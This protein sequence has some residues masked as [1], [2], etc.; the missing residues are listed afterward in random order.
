MNQIIF[1]VVIVLIEVTSIFTC[2]YDVYGRKARLHVS[3]GPVR[4]C[5]VATCRKGERPHICTEDYDDAF[6]TPCP[7]RKYNSLDTV[8]SLHILR[9]GDCRDMS[10]CNERQ[11]MVSPGN[12][13]SDTDCRCDIKRGYY[14]EIPDQRNADYCLV[15]EECDA[16]TQLNISGHCETC[17]N[18]TFKKFKGHN[19]C[20]PCTKC[21]T[22]GI[23]VIVNCT[24]KENTICGIIKETSHTASLLSSTNDDIVNN[25]IF[26]VITI[27][28][29]I[30]IVITIS[31]LVYRIKLF[32]KKIPPS[33]SSIP[34][35]SIET[36]RLN[37]DHPRTIIHVAPGANVF[38]QRGEKNIINKNGEDL[39]IKEEEENCNNDDDDIVIMVEG[40]PDP[41]PDPDP[42]PIMSAMMIVEEPSMSAMMIVEEPEPSMSAMM[43]VEEP[44]MSAMMIVEEPS[45]SAMT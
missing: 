3:E 14:S 6:C 27:S 40:E 22:I 34:S 18:E 29:G 38:Y 20:I 28:L 21:V 41:D 16:G 19:P 7:P 25:T 23:D 31:C 12:S 4:C 37:E 26:I 24:A 10:V 8:T 36:K 42:E 45:M 9:E 35:S 39:V 11:V 32:R 5:I 44:S 33:S 13:T 30:I 15:G 2:T 1:I 17:P 43:I